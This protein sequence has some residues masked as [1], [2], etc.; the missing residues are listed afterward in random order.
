[1]SAEQT[2]H[3]RYQRHKS[4][5]KSCAKTF[6]TIS[7]LRLLVVLAGISTAA[8]VYFLYDPLYAGLII[9][10]FGLLFISLMLKHARVEHRLHLV[11]ALAEVNRRYMERIKGGWVKFP[12][13]GENFVDSSHPYSSDLDIFGPKSLF[14]WLST[15]RTYRGRQ[16]LAS[17][18]ADPP[19]DLASIQM[20]Q[21]AVRELSSKLDFCQSLE[22]QSLLSEEVS[23]NPEKL[24]EYARRPLG[25]KGLLV[26][27]V[28]PLITITAFAL[29][30]L[31]GLPV[32]L[33]V[34]FL[35]L[36]GGLLLRVNKKLGDT[37]SN[38]Y[39]FRK[40]LDGF[41]SMLATIEK[42]P[43]KNQDL[44]ALRS[45]LLSASE[46]ASAAMKQLER[47]SD[48]ID[49]RLQPLIH[50]A[51]N[52]FLMWDVQCAISLEKWIER[53]GKRVDR[54]FDVIAAFEAWCS[55]AVIS[56][57]Y[58]D[59]IFPLIEAAGQK[60]TARGL[61]HPLLPQ[62]RCVRNDVTIDNQSCIITG[63]NMSGKSTLLR[64]IGTDLVLA[65]AGSAVCAREMK[66]S[67]MDLYTSMVIRDDL[68]S[69]IS[70][71]YA[72]LTRISSILEQSRQGKPMLYL[73]DEIFHG[74]NS[75]D[76]IAGAKTVLRNL[77]E[78]GV[79]GLIST[80]DFELCALEQEKWS[81]FKNYHFE[82]HYKNGRIEFDYKLRPGRCT[83]SN[84][85]YLMKMV[86]ID[87]SE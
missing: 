21:Q 30:Y 6:N 17:L 18:L 27:R 10:L 51:L 4:L 61:G 63:S 56:H 84:A 74:T 76:R 38:V 37:L 62:D 25:I 36:Q 83:T 59:W 73:I 49:I 75:L 68:V 9:I 77:T 50:F 65:Y 47:I 12:D 67:V 28:M 29:Y 43:F 3:T 42:E 71:F 85:R 24:I 16:H 66:C 60:V 34:L 64:A 79:I 78:N 46:S 33:P 52:L 40:G 15:A 86:G 72:E 35:I 14:Q 19:R 13:C 53:H 20:R 7:N 32:E 11:Q 41:G 55:L 69:G 81:N 48:A 58:P 80:H 5:E 2:F 45:E 57:L 87:V 1:M 26:M 70:T 22:S 23:K 39:K 44:A 54:W 8:V 31:K 82:E